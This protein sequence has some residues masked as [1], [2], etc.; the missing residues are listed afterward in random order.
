MFILEATWW[1]QRALWHLMFSGVFERYPTLK[2]VTTETGTAWVPDT[3]ENLESFFHR[4]RYS[5]YGSEIRV[6]QPGGGRHVAHSQ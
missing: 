1:T 6:R 2:Y 5:K 3:L 4:M